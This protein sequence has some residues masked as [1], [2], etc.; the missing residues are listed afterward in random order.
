MTNRAVGERLVGLK[1]VAQQLRLG[2]RRHVVRGD[3]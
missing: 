1:L 2:L 3:E